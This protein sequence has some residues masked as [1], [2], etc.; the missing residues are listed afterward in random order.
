MDR[1]VARHL[2]AR[3]NCDAERIAARFGLRYRCIEAERP[4]VKRRYGI[5]Y[6]DGSIRIRL[7]HVVS[8]RPL[9]YSSLIDTLCHELAHLRHFH[10]GPQFKSF[11]EQILAWARKEKIYRPGPDPLDPGRLAE[12]VLRERQ[13]THGASDPRKP[14]RRPANEPLQPELG[15]GGVGWQTSRKA[16]PAA[17]RLIPKRERSREPE[18]LSLFSG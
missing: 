13:G 4:N 14:A 15:F 16:A 12:P 7:I 11:Y 6:D 8:R 10:H 5:C 3:L 2:I 18:Q 9:K 17:P 1:R